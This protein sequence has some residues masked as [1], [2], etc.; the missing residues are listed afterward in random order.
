MNQS[1]SP[2]VSIGLPV[3]NG[4]GHLQV[5]IDAILNQSY[6]N[7]EL[8]VCDNASTDETVKIAEHA[9]LQ[10]R[11]VKL[12]RN[13]KNLGIFNNFNLALQEASGDFFMWSAHDDLHSPEFI[14]ECVKQLI[15]NPDAVL[16]QT[17]VAV[18]LARPDQVIYLS[19]LNT[20]H[21][22]RSV[23]RRYKETLYRF[24]A[25]AIYGL[26]RLE[27]LKSIPGFRNVPGGDLLWVQEVTLLGNF[28][29]SERILFHYIARD[30]WNSFQSDLKNLDPEST[31]FKKGIAL[32]I[33]AFFDRIKSIYRSK[34]SVVSKSLLIIIAVQYSIQTLFIRALLRGL[35]QLGGRNPAR[36]LRHKLYWRFLHNPNIQIVDRNLFLNR[37]INPTVGL[38]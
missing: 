24:P 4:E 15:A 36:A 5:S 20:F 27:Q 3:F 13:G 14:E 8:I 21:G 9:V 37:V 25:V 19:S 6:Q 30:K 7:I 17:R 2:L 22:K 32:A 26:Y 1:D 29:Q 31:H 33:M 12:V 16:C 35:G 10:D 38:L 18:C 11:R 23:G 34:E 28:I